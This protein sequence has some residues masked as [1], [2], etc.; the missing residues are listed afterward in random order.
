MR[1]LTNLYPA[2]FQ[3]DLNRRHFSEA[4][5]VSPLA[6]IIGIFQELKVFLKYFLLYK[7]PLR[8]Q[9]TNNNQCEKENCH[10]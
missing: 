10:I 8:K 6:C 3:T 2:V 5:Q 1:I 9:S 4:L 7:E